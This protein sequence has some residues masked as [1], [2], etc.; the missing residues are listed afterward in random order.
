MIRM[1]VGLLMSVPMLGAL[2]AGQ[3]AVDGAWSRATA[4]GQKVAG[5]FLDIVSAR[6]ARLVAVTS[7]VAQ[8][9]ELHWMTMEGGTMRMRAVDVIEL[10]AGKAVSLKPGGYHV[11][12]FGLKRPLIPGE[13]VPLTLT[14]ETADG[15]RQML[16]IGVAVRNLDGSPPP[17]HH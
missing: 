13:S 16:D 17:H 12:L 11:M 15:A 10:P 6:D 1:L 9:G 14:V 8:T 5:V 7:P 4:P 2:A 3:V